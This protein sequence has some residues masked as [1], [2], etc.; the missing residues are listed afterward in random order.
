MNGATFGPT[1]VGVVGPVPPA[2]CMI[3]CC[4]EKALFALFGC[5]CLLVFENMASKAF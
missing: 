4:Y 3:Q 5:I 2:L 1:K